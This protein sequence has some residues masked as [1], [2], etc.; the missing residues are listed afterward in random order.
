MDHVDPAVVAVN[1]LDVECMRG[2]APM[3]TGTLVRPAVV[4]TAAHC[5]RDEAPSSLAVLF[6][7]EGDPGRGPPGAGL[8][9]R[10][11]H[12][13]AVRIHPGYRADDLANDVA[14][15]EL[16]SAAT[17][18]PVPL[19][20]DANAAGSPAR[21]VGFGTAGSDGSSYKRTGDVTV[22]AVRETEFTYAAAPAMTCGGD[23]G[24]PV[25]RA[26]EGGGDEI[27]G[28]TSRGDASCREY[29]IAIRVDTLPSDFI[30]RKPSP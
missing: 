25:F 19:A 2:G 14:V 6:G 26:R 3:C 11:F 18:V 16:E 4:L 8:E 10:F 24:G 21:A 15:L 1:T 5:V 7:D 22:T 13:T 27:I 12:V 9:G 17:A 23:S 20:A 28:V 30:E 29:G